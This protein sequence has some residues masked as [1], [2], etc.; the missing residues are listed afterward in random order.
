MAVIY[1]TI[2]APFMDIMESSVSVSPYPF[3]AHMILDDIIIAV[4]VCLWPF[5]PLSDFF[6]FYFLLFPWVSCF[7]VIF[8]NMELSVMLWA[9]V[10]Q[11]GRQIGWTIRLPVQSQDLPELLTKCPWARHWTPNCS[12]CAGWCLA[13]FPPPPVYECVCEWVNVMHYLCEAPWIKAL[14]KCTIYHL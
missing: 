14:Y 12:R 11:S 8:P 9:A 6:V 13:W 10:A 5:Y 7:R 4:S 3:Y 2:S 1:Y